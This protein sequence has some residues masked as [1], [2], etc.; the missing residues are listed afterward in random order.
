MRIRRKIVS[1]KIYRVSITF[2]TRTM[3]QDFKDSKLYKEIIKFIDDKNLI[4]YSEQYDTWTSPGEEYDFEYPDSY[5]FN[6][7]IKTHA[8]KVSK[9]FN[10]Y[11]VI[12]DSGGDFAW[13]WPKSDPMYDDPMW[14]GW[15]EDVDD[16]PGDR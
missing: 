3:E 7:L 6:F 5:E 4:L 11:L 10:L 9:Q 1:E 12:D 13:I 16:I 2:E 14:Y 15:N 8:T